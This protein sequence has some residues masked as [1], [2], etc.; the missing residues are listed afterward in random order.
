MIFSLDYKAH[1]DGPSLVEKS[2]NVAGWPNTDLEMLE[3]DE[4]TKNVRGSG[5]LATSVQQEFFHVML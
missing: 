4:T 2:K 3:S 5:P 1:F